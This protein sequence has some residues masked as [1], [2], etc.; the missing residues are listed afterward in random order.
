MMPNGKLW[1]LVTAVAVLALLTS[2]TWAVY[3]LSFTYATNKDCWR[4]L[5]GDGTLRDAYTVSY[6]IEDW[7]RWDRM[8][9]WNAST[10]QTS[11]VTRTLHMDNMMI[12]ANGD[13]TYDDYKATE[14]SW[15]TSSATGDGH[16][17]P[18]GDG[19]T[20]DADD[21]SKTYGVYM[22]GFFGTTEG[23]ATKVGVL[24][25]FERGR[26]VNA[27]GTDVFVPVLRPDRPA[28]F[29]SAGFRYD[30]NGDGTYTY[31]IIPKDYPLTD[32]PFVD[33]EIDFGD[34]TL[35]LG[36][37]NS[38]GTLQLGVEDFRVPDGGLVDAIFI[39]CTISVTGYLPAST[40]NVDFD[41]DGTYDSYVKPVS[42]WLQDTYAAEGQGGAMGVVNYARLAWDVNGDG[43]I[44]GSDGTFDFPIGDVNADGTADQADRDYIDTIFNTLGG[45]SN[46][47]PTSYFF[48]RGADITGDDLVNQDDLDMWDVTIPEPVTL[49]AVGAGLAAF[50]GLRTR[51]R[52]Q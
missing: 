16:I 32:R 6:T 1:T 36:D 28:K 49:L 40:S 52:L 30:Y 13:G 2:P 48:N 22:G 27:A 20:Y 37:V 51:R 47:L 26:A 50:T 31:V 8:Y 5:N 33:G 23:T 43:T 19:T 7:A 25:T 21:G 17:I 42:T 12:D 39:D 24:L 9:T 35:S 11:G 18:L 29:W 38:D 4:D 10:T 44:D 14:G 45:G 34:P 41:G 15:W 46:V 3:T